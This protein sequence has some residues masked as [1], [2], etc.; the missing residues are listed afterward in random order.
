MDRGVSVGDAVVRN[1]DGRPSSTGRP[2]EIEL[3]RI[4]WCLL[5]GR[6]GRAVT[7]R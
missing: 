7:V 3:R 2:G 6:P 4:L 5:T 1:F